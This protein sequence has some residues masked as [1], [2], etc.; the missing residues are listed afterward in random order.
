MRGGARLVRGK[1]DENPS[2]VP[3]FPALIL[4]F[5]CYLASRAITDVVVTGQPP[6][7]KNALNRGGGSENFPQWLFAKRRAEY[8]PNDLTNHP[9]APS[10][11]EK[12][13]NK[14]F[15]LRGIF[16]SGE[17]ATFSCMTPSNVREGCKFFCGIRKWFSK[18]EWSGGEFMINRTFRRKNGLHYFSAD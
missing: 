14:Y 5:G 1:N 7:Q 18:M 2:S 15:I 10:T 16:F 3:G 4:S 8:T 17:H 13:Q 9:R 12:K 11:R 6:S